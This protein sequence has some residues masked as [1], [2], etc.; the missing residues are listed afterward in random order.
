MASNSERQVKSDNLRWRGKLIHVNYNHFPCFDSKFVDKL[1]A[2]KKCCTSRLQAN[3][4]N[5]FLLCVLY[6]LVMKGIVN[7]VTQS[8]DKIW[9]WYQQHALLDQ[10]L[11]LDKQTEDSKEQRQVKKN[12]RLPQIQSETKS[13]G[14]SRAEICP[15]AHISAIDRSQTLFTGKVSLCALL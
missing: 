3:I 12:R 9:L 8:R 1:T 11:C 6:L 4:E 13:K 14:L 15:Q 7:G 10:K 2:E 5:F